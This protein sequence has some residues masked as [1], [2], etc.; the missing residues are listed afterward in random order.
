M[1]VQDIVYHGRKQPVRVAFLT[2][3]A[4]IGGRDGEFYI[5]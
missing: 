2:I 5:S 3:S 1:L 4:I